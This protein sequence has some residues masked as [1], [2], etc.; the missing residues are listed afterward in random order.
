MSVVSD[1]LCN[2]PIV[3]GI[4]NSNILRQGQKVRISWIKVYLNISSYN[5]AFH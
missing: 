1:I 3:L 4:D 5:V 2:M